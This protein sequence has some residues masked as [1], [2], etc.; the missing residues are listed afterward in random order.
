MLRYINVSL[1]Y[2]VMSFLWDLSKNCH[3][4]NNCL[5]FQLCKTPLFCRIIV[6]PLTWDYIDWAYETLLHSVVVEQESPIV[7]NL[8][9]LCCIS[10]SRN[11]LRF[12]G[13]APTSICHIF[14]PS[15][16]HAPY[17]R[18]H[19]S[20]DHNFWYTYVK[21]WYLQ[22]FFSFCQNLYFLG[23]W[24]VKGQKIAQNEK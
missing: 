7:I 11:A 20:S 1:I 12:L 9:K 24:G 8:Y 5:A 17:L 14:C 22:V 4:A 15:F 3:L 6:W 19:I 13:G 2:I 16:C 21:W 10:Y 23:S 18:N